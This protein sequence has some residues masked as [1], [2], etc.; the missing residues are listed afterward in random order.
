[1]STSFWSVSALGVSAVAICATGCVGGQ[2]LFS[3]PDFEAPAVLQYVQDN[4]GEF[5]SDPNEPLANVAPGTVID[6]LSA[7]DGCWGALFTAEVG[8]YA[9]F[10]AYHFDVENGVFSRYSTL[11]F[12]NGAAFLRFHLVSVEEGPFAFVGDN[13]LILTDEHLLSNY[14]MV[15]NQITGTLVEIE[16]DPN[17][18]PV[19]RDALVTLDGERMLLFIDV[20]A[21]ED[22]T[23]DSDVLVFQRFECPN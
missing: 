17:S 18:P 12:S 13:A 8:P 11:A 16:R 10:V 21:P 3:D 20:A 1:M 9:F 19:Q 6:D 4:V 7:I 14:D 15:N 22:V 23:S 2:P 5:L